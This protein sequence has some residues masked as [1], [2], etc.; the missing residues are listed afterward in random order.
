M[1]EN[2]ILRKIIWNGVVYIQ[3]ENWWAPVPDGYGSL[4]PVFKRVRD[5][6]TRLK[7]GPG[8]PYPVP[9]KWR[10]RDSRTRFPAIPAS[11]TIVNG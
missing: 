7:T 8:V 6:R 1:G 4:G 9:A 5:S 3:P 2:I 10:V 11:P